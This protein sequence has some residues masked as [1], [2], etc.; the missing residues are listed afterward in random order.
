MRPGLAET[1][2]LAPYKIYP[3]HYISFF[4]SSAANGGADS[5]GYSLLKSCRLEE[6]E[7]RDFEDGGAGG[8][9]TAFSLRSFFT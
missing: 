9:K 1:N 8:E 4:A 7:S 3:E 6:L 5:A 2:T